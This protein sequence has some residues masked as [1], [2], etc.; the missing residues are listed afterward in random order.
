MY[1]ALDAGHGPGSRT[2]GVYDPGAML[3]GYQ[4]H[5]LAQELVDGL[6]ADLKALGHRIYL[7]TGIFTSR[8]DKAR[9]AGVDFYL[10][11]HFNGGPGTGTEAFVNTSSS[12]PV[13]RAFSTDVCARFA[14]VMGIPNRGLKYANFAVLSA[15]KSDALVEVCF[16]ADVKKYLANKDAVELAILNALLK[17]H[18]ENEVSTLPRI[19]KEDDMD[20]NISILVRP[21]KEAALLKDLTPVLVKHGV[22]GQVIRYSATGPHVAP[23]NPPVLRTK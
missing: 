14:K 23:I 20:H 2:A 6:A 17:A 4:E 15:N 3:Q 16:P 21:E 1:C 5:K 18:G 13:A 7:P 11:V 8:D 12:T 10:S 22:Y 9:A 19:A